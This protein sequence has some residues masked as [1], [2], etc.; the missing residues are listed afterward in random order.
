MLNENKVVITMVRDE[1]QTKFGIRKVIDMPDQ[2]LNPHPFLDF[3]AKLEKM[4]KM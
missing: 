3:G 4:E 2:Y 1:A